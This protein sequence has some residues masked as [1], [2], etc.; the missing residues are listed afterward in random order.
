MVGS[1]ARARGS[2]FFLAAAQAEIKRLTSPR[3]RKKNNRG[4]GGE[5]ACLR[6]K[7]KSKKIKSLFKVSEAASPAAKVLG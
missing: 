3:I 1:H 2:P 6:K 4:V 5:E 7:P